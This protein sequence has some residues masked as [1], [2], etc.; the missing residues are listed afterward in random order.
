MTDYVKENI[1]TKQSSSCEDSRI[2]SEDGNKER[3]I[4]TQTSSCEGPQTPYTCSLLKYLDRSYLRNS[5]E[6]RKVYTRGRK[7]DGRFMTVFIYQNN[8]SQHR[9]GITASQKALGKAV[10]RNR[11]K[12]LLRESFRLNKQDLN[13]LQAKY[14]WVLN[15]KRSLLSVKVFSPL[16][17]LRGIIKKIVNDEKQ[18]TPKRLEQK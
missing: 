5:A 9:L 4:S 17:E 10:N 15:A 3:P 14:D 11:S 18:L 2:Q 1:S 8:L 12:R 13:N 16:E 7:Y 6:F